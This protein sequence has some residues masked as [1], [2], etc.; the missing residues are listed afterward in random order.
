MNVFSD[1]KD[2]VFIRRKGRQFNLSLFRLFFFFLSISCLA[3]SIGWPNIWASVCFDS[4]QI[5]KGDQM[6][7]KT[8][9]L[10]SLES[11]LEIR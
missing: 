5:S 1:N 2:C 9:S 7:L 3:P 4:A 11:P 6:D 8:V 10:L